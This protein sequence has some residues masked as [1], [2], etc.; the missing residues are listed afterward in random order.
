[1]I[2]IRVICAQREVP[3]VIEALARSLVLG[4]VR[5]GKTFDGRRVRLYVSAEIRPA[6]ASPRPADDG[7]E[8]WVQSP[9]R[10]WNLT[11]GFLDRRGYRWDW[12]GTYGSDGTPVLECAEPDITDSRPLPD[13]DVQHGPLHTREW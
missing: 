9:G 13:L 2:E 1:M 8:V 7:N 6:S 3:D 10:A 12:T 11:S 4:P 5:K